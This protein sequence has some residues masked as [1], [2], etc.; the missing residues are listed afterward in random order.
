MILPVTAVISLHLDLSSSLLPQLILRVLPP[1]HPPPCCLL[2]STCCSFQY[3]VCPRQTYFLLPKLEKSTEGSLVPRGRAYIFQQTRHLLV[4]CAIL[5]ISKKLLLHTCYVSG[6]MPDAG[7]ALS[8]KT[9]SLPS[10]EC[11]VEWG[12]NQLY[13]G[14]HYSIMDLYWS[15]AKGVKKTQVWTLGFLWTNYRTF[16]N[17][18]TLPHE[19]WENWIR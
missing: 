2:H 13:P 4:I 6:T 16:A 17:H 11:S 10:E 8:P 18:W 14:L 19:R 7:S 1:L 12:S 3:C 15:S 9:G 5:Y